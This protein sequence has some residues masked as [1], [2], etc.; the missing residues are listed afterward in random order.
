MEVNPIVLDD[1]AGDVVVVVVEG[2]V[3]T[4]AVV[5]GPVVDVV[6]LEVVVVGPT[7]VSVPGVGLIV[8]VSGP[9]CASM[10]AG[11]KVKMPLALAVDAPTLISRI[12]P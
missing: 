9:L 11:V 5:V 1:A 10:L 2:V 7:I 4:V 8:I 12:S 3:A 6:E